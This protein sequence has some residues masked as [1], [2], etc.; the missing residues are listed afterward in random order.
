MVQEVTGAGVAPMNLGIVPG[1][2][3]WVGGIIYN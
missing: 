2:R 3:V 1:K